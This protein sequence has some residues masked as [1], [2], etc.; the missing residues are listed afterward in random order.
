MSSDGSITYKVEVDNSGAIKSLN[1]ID[2]AA[3]ETGKKGQKHSKAFTAAIG[4]AAAGAVVSMK[5]LTSAVRQSI[6]AFAEYEQLVGGVETLF[7]DSADVVMEY[8]QNAYKTAG[9]SANQYMDTITSFSASLIN[10]LGG[11]TK[12]AAELGNMAVTDMADNVNKMGTT[13]E[14]VQNAYAGFARGQY[15]MLDNLRLGYSGSREQME[16]LL[17]DAEK[18]SGIHYDIESY[19]DIVEAIHVIQTEMGITGTTAKEAA[20]TI[21]GSMNMAKAAWMN[22]LTGLADQDADLEALTD[23]LI[24]TVITAATNVTKVIPQ[25]LTSL[26][27]SVPKLITELGPELVNTLV[28]LIPVLVGCIPQFLD[29]G[30]QLFTALIEALDEIIPQLIE[31]LPDLITQIGQALQDNMPLLISAAIQLF[32]GITIALFQALPQILMA[33]LDMGVQRVSGILQGIRENIGQVWRTIVDGVSG[34]IDKVKEFLG[35]SSPSKYMAEQV[36]QWIPSGV[37]VGITA[38]TDSVDKA[39]RSLT[40]AVAGYDFGLNGPA[41]PT[42][43]VAYSAT[44]N[45]GSIVGEIQSLRAAIEG[46][47]LYLDGN[48]LVGGIAPQMDAALGRLEMIGAR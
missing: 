38:N 27:Q 14:A 43:T 44:L 35:I 30:L 13:M 23:N 24:S 29:A 7:K 12:K 37:A 10:S 18:I 36:G 26:F 46:L 1:Q 28:G 3:E 20:T 31:M 4:I 48:L 47:K 17:A 25:I 2:D 42:A 19:A 40:G 9:M 5:A 21:Q 16:K 22:W 33:C 32:L 34:A 8:A 45:A 11:D 41:S 6:D 15:N 39:M